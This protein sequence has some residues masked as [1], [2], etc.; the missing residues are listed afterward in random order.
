MSISE[1]WDHFLFLIYVVPIIAG[2]FLPS[3]KNWKHVSEIKC[4]DEG[5]APCHE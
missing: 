4:K 3:G 5:A 2:A 1:R